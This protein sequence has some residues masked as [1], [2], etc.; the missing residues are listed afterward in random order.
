MEDCRIRD[1]DHIRPHRTGG[2]TTETNGQGLCRLSNLVKEL[3]G[4][5]V[6]QDA[7]GAVRWTTPTGHTYD[8]P[9]PR[10]H[11]RT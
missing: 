4:W 8:A 7:V 6:S 2:P 10:P 9:P 5:H 3:P 11:G 1:I